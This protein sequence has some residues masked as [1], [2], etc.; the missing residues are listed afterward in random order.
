MRIEGANETK[1]ALEGG[2]HMGCGKKR[3]GLSLVINV[4]SLTYQ[5]YDDY[6]IIGFELFDLLASST[7]MMRD[8]T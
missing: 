2:V 4:G 5:H 1:E 3:S 7:E 8:G 6:R